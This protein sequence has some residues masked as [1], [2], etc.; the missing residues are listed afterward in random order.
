MPFKNKKLKPPVVTLL[1]DFGT[2]DA[3][4]GAMKGVL[5]SICPQVR[6]VDLSHE[7]PSQAVA[8]GAFLLRSVL[9]YFPRGIVHLAVVDPGVGSSRKAVAV[10]SRGRFFVGPDNGLLPAALV[11]WGVDRAVELTEKKFHLPHPSS[12]FQGRDIFAPVAAH[13]ARGVSFGKLGKNLPRLVPGVLSKPRKTGK[14]WEGEVLWVDRFG[15]LI[16]NFQRQEAP[17]GSRFRIGSRE[18][19]RVGTHYGEVPPGGIL[20][21]KGSS[22]YWEISVN[23]GR[24][25]ERLRAGIGTK[26]ALF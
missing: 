26:V 21:L 7:V 16:T 11:D 8:C 1:T 17:P 13:L 24:A 4:V 20:A 18:I 23:R 5:L 6:C 12:T 22:G 2:R 19:G 15:N 25:D 3:F 14:R 9:E 10:E